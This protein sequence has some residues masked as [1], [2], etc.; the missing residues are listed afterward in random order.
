MSGPSYPSSEDKSVRTGP[1]AKG[2]SRIVS[3][4]A[5][6]E[7]LEMLIRACRS[8]GARSV[9]GFAR[10]AVLDKLEAM[11]APRLTLST[12]L[13]T[14]SQTLAQLDAALSEASRKIRRLLGPAAGERSSDQPETR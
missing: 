2:K 1:A 7:E 13:N 6:A 11:R 14:L 10:A 4:R 8:S 9:S 12:D 5:S 3:F